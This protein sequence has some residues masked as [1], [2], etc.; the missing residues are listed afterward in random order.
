[1]ELKALFLRA[2]EVGKELSEGDIV[3]STSQKFT[4]SIIYRNRY[5]VEFGET[6]RRKVKAKQARLLSLL[7]APTS[8]EKVIK[9]RLLEKE[10]TFL[11]VSETNGKIL[12]K[13]Y[14]GFSELHDGKKE[15][16]AYA[17]GWAPNKKNC[18]IFVYDWSNQSTVES[19]LRTFQNAIGPF[20]SANEIQSDAFYNS[21]Y[22]I[23]RECDFTKNFLRIKE[24]SKQRN[25]VDFS[26]IE[27]KKIKVAHNLIN[28]VQISR[29][30]KIPY[31]IFEK[32]NFDLEHNAVIE[33]LGAGCDNKG[34]PFLTLY[35]GHPERP[36]FYEEQPILKTSTSKYDEKNKIFNQKSQIME[37]DQ[38]TKSIQTDM[39]EN[40]KVFNER[41]KQADYET[42]IEDENKSEPVKATIK[43]SSCGCS[44]N[45]TNE[46]GLV[47]VIGNIHFDFLSDSNKDSF[48]HYL[49]KELSIGVLIENI[50]KQTYLAEELSWIVMINDVPIYAVK[51][52]GAFAK[53]GYEMLIDFFT[54]LH[55]TKN[56]IERVAIPGIISGTTVLSSGQEVPT[57]TPV[58]RGMASWNTKALVDLVSSKKSTG[59]TNQLNDFLS[60]I[61]FELQNKGRNPADRALNY[62]ATNLFQSSKIFEESIKNGLELSDIS[63]EKSKFYRP[64][65]DLWDFKVVF[66][67]PSKRHEEARK[68]Y[69]FTIDTTEAIPTTIGDIRHW[70]IY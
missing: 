25:S 29:Q 22:N 62:A 21:I 41:P 67:N 37:N 31:E 9:D 23:I 39:S 19:A 20:R 43:P 65:R 50:K 46:G 3:L 44:S 24:E 35:V 69:G 49:G 15:N 33:H 34:S 18:K 56:P 40:S 13:L 57:I 12:Y 51:P 10:I 58:L 14:F 28:L 38:I 61:Y 59:L 42:R 45:Q 54:D 11:G 70:S 4:N 66:F 36:T 52:K 2:Y 68:V 63:V 26:L 30:L 1:M 6:G 5:F 8:V 53:E 48:T 47:Y 17:L 7:K 64:D 27:G 32:W 55:K 60:R 16:A